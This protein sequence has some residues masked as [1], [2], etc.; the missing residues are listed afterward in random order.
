MSITRPSDERT[1]DT[2]KEHGG[3]VVQLMAG[4]RAGQP[5]RF[6]WEQR[7]RRDPEVTG[8]ALGVLLLMATYGDLDGCGIK[9]GQDRLAVEAGCDVRTVRRA[10][11]KATRRDYLRLV[12]RGH[13]ITADRSTPSEYALQ[14]PGEQSQPDTGDRLGSES[15]GSQPDTGDL[16]AVTQPDTPD[17]L[18]PS[19]PDSQPDTNG[20]PTGHHA[21]PTRSLPVRTN[22]PTPHE[23]TGHDPAPADSI[24]GGWPE[25][26]Y[27]ANALRSLVTLVD[28]RR[29]PIDAHELLADAYRL[30]DGDPW[31]GYVHHVKP[32]T[33]AELDTARD[34]AAVLRGRLGRPDTARNPRPRQTRNQAAIAARVAR[35]RFAATS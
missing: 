31:A 12:H 33:D 22:P 35:F 20:E 10:I 29:L 34:P 21:P 25:H 19:Q 8:S 13:R 23:P 11:D 18:D 9:V 28:E 5:R 26:P 3:T 24:R 15:E 2:A 27:E 6:G 4:R 32:L 1:R 7:I 30:G 17:L 14:L 16:L